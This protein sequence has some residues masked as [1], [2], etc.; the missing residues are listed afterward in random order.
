VAAAPEALGSRRDE[1]DV[2]PGIAYFN[3]ASISPLPHRVRAAGEE[4]LE[5]RAR[6]WTIGPEQWFGDVERLRERFADL[7][8]ADTD[9]VALVPATSYAFASVA[10]N[11][12]LSAGDRILV[13][14]RE[15]PSGIHTWRAL[16]RTSGV[17]LVTV[18]IEPG[19]EWTEAIL[20]ALDE[21]IRVVSV[22]NVHWTDGGLVDLDAIAERTHAVGARL[23]VDVSQSAGA[24]PLDVGRLRPDMLCA[25]GYKW[26]FGPLGVS[27]LYLAPELRQGEPL[28]HNWINRAGSE[29]FAA[30][31]EYTD[32]FQP[33]ARRFD[34]GH[35]SS[36]NL[37]P[38]SIA[39]L[40]QV[41]EWQVPRIAATLAE[42][43][44]VIERG[45]AELG[46]E[47]LP[48]ARRGPHMLG[49]RLPAET[50]DRALE[51][52]AAAECHAAVRGDSLRISPHLHNTPD[53]VERL[54]GALAELAA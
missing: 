30:L 24:M 26:L 8:G 43:T 51:V 11:L 5:R 47:P 45:A 53:E 2:P 9:G 38:M 40:E 19:G 13:L 31:V 15:Y 46:L 52:L 16:A 6:P 14:A 17:E 33:G 1:L 4:A 28:E 54:L 23:V 29:D 27:Y 25:A 10:R 41:A 36:F 35:R 50:R 3:T 48:A 34:V 39:A 21:R 12:G 49:V 20:A 7:I 22:P 37:V 44:A 42:M 18:E 32:E